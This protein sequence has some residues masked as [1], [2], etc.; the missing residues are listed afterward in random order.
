MSDMSL[1]MRFGIYFGVPQT[2]VSLLMILGVYSVQYLCYF[3]LKDEL[4]NELLANKHENFNLTSEYIGKQSVQFLKINGQT[5]LM[6]GNLTEKYH[7]KSLSIKDYVSSENLLNGV[8]VEKKDI[9]DTPFPVWYLNSK[10]EN[11]TQLK[12]D[13]GAYETFKMSKVIRSILEAYLG[14]DE[15]S[16]YYVGYSSGFYYTQPSNYNC[17]FYTN[18]TYNP[19]PYICGN[20]FHVACTDWYRQT[21]ES[22]ESYPV[23]LYPI[24]DNCKADIEQLVCQKFKYKGYSDSAVCMK[25]AFVDVISRRLSNLYMKDIVS[26]TDLYGNVVYRYDSKPGNKSLI[27]YEFGDDVNSNFAQEF[28]EKIV[29]LFNQREAN[30]TKY[31]LNNLSTRIITTY[32][33]ILDGIPHIY[34]LAMIIS[35]GVVMDNLQSAD[36][37]FQNL[38]FFQGVVYIYILAM[39]HILTFIIT[40]NMANYLTAQYY[41]LIDKLEEMKKGNIMKFENIREYSCREINQLYDVFNKLAV[42]YRLNDDREFES[43]KNAIY[44]YKR[45]IVLF[46]TVEND[47]AL[48]YTHYHLGLA[49]MLIPKYKK[50]ALAFEECLSL[51]SIE[52]YDKKSL[53]RVCVGLIISYTK[54]KDTDKAMT[55]L[56]C[57]YDRLES[58]K[59]D[60]EIRKFFLVECYFKLKNMFPIQDILEIIKNDKKDLDEISLQIYY[61]Y[62]AK[63]KITQGMHKSA[64]KS[65]VKTIVN[66][67]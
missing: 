48:Y 43:L 40:Y 21:M 22:D 33:M 24:Y 60:N 52:L 51:S 8:V 20:Y 26:V 18:S 3:D 66:T 42:V 67:I 63:S 15:Y 56:R 5:M 45:A 64:F 32:P 12:E 35:E 37:Y 25:F 55:V 28:R 50:A 36:R 30:S 62:K 39:S 57:I 4:I 16:K 54:L 44:L 27:E 23:M 11:E 13:S 10:T 47:L 6:I 14:T 34:T 59:L 29:P 1:K 38:L 19:Q 61:Y 31:T 2:V 41:D 58:E 17:K 9:T 7:N 46:N 49:Y 53:Y 65:L